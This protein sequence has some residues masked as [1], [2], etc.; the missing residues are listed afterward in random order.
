MS[1]PAILHAVAPGARTP[2][3]SS[4]IWSLS[5]SASSSHPAFTNASASTSLLRA[6]RVPRVAPI[7]TLVT[8]K[9][10][11]GVRGMSM[12]RRMQKPLDQLPEAEA[13]ER[14]STL[15]DNE[16]KQPHDPWASPMETLDVQ[17]PPP[18][19]DKHLGIKDSLLASFQNFAKNAISMRELADASSF[20]HLKKSSKWS[21]Q[22]FRAR[23]TSETV[24]LAPWRDEFLDIYRRAYTAAAANDKKASRRYTTPEFGASLRE[25]LPIH[26]GKTYTYKWKLHDVIKPPRIESVRATNGHWGRAEP[27]TGNR[28]FVN[29]L[30]RFESTQTLHVFDAKTGALVNGVGVTAPR[31]VLEY[32]VFE[33]R[34]W[35]ENPWVIRERMYESSS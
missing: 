32:L 17:I 29:V 33:K 22:I 4:L 28:L 10:L 31:R 20:P 35:Y 21:P 24:W 13:L 25:A 6:K 18:L 8:M 5:S 7:A 1:G 15:V 23:S 3:F 16:H 11:G 34:L 14:L 12:A 27:V 2:V 30:V 19:F 26:P 9:S